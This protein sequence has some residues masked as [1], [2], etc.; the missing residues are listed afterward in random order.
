MRYNPNEGGKAAGKSNRELPKK[1]MEKKKIMRLL[2]IFVLIALFGLS[3][4]AR[5]SGIGNH[6]SDSST[7]SD[8]EKSQREGS[9]DREKTMLE[10]FLIL[11]DAVRES[12]NERYSNIKYGTDAYNAMNAILLGYDEENTTK[13]LD[14]IYYYANI[15]SNVRKASVIGDETAVEFANKID[16][17]YDGPYA[18]D[19]IALAETYMD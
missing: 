14:Q 12:D 7:A 11:R 8:T 15:V 5:K 10:Y 2:V 1:D 6:A 18:Y 17:S 16:L 3:A 19:I 4:C 13:T 9:S